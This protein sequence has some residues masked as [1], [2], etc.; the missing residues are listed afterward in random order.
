MPNSILPIYCFVTDIY[1]N[2]VGNVRINFSAPDF[3]YI[4]P[5]GYSNATDS[6]GMSS[7]IDFY[8]QGDV[9]LARLIAA[10]ISPYSDDTTELDTALVNVI[11]YILDFS[12][13]EDTISQSEQTQLYCRVINPL[14]SNQTGNIYI[15][16]YSLN[17]GTVPSNPINSSD[18]SF[19]GL[20]STVFYEA[21]GDT[22][23]VA[24]LVAHAFN[25]TLEKVIGTDTTNVVVVE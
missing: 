23:G 16:F 22:T 25:S 9:G 4:F 20:Q 2:Q 10:M 7:E 21:P 14:T 8:P 15:R 24:F 19:S 1:G 13:A 5:Y 3:G 18:T 6:T 12:T 11:P 17:F